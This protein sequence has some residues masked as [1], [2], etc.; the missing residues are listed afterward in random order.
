MLRFGGTNVIIFGGICTAAGFALTTLVP[1]WQIALV[2]YALIGV[3]SANI[4]PV[5]YTSAGRQTVVP[6]HMAVSAITT[7]G[8]AG[9][10]AGPAAIGFIAHVSSLSAAFLILAIL[11]LVVAASGRLLRVYT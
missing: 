2:G 5:L 1:L 11:Q 4:V 9:I 3:G 10:L 6:E 7:L 8:Y